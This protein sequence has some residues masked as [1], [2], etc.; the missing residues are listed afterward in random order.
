MTKTELAQNNSALCKALVSLRQPNVSPDAGKFCVTVKKDL[1]YCNGRIISLDENFRNCVV[2]GYDKAVMDAIYTIWA[3]RLDRSKS[4]CSIRY[5][6]IYARMNPGKKL[7]LGEDTHAKIRNTVTKLRNLE[8]TLS[9]VNDLNRVLTYFGYNVKD[10]DFNQVEV[11]GGRFCIKD[12]LINARVVY[13]TL[14]TKAKDGSPLETDGVILQGCPILYQYAL[15]QHQVIT[16]DADCL[17]LPGRMTEKKIAIRDYL[18]SYIRSEGHRNENFSSMVGYQT[19]YENSGTKWSD[20]K[21]LQ[22][23]DRE[24]VNSILNY[25]KQTGFIYDYKKDCKNIEIE[26]TKKKS[27]RV[28]NRNNAE[29]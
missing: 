20:D 25:Y 5:T 12:K 17:N 10:I 4:E 3:S 2:N 15:A 14:P 19:I 23:K 27:R 26:V 18:I 6:E 24:L 8:I 21:R 1:A 7:R 28:R 11:S 29:E 22:A 13:S 9:L 16:T